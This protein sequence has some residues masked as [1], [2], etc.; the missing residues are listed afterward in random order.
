[1]VYNTFSS[2]KLANINPY[3]L[4]F[5]GIPGLLMNIET[6]PDVNISGTVKDYYILLNSRIRYLHQLLQGFK[7]K[8]YLQ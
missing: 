2:L 7:S 3:E 6:T 5:G 8:R 4:V 1:M